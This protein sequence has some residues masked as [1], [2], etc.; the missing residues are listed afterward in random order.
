ML[1]DERESDE[2]IYPTTG[3][4][5]KILAI[6]LLLVSTINVAQSQVVIVKS[7]QRQP[8]AGSSSSAGNTGNTN[9]TGTTNAKSKIK[10]SPSPTPKLVSKS[11]PNAKLSQRTLTAD[12]TE[13]P[14][15]FKVVV[16]QS[17]PVN[18]G[19]RSLIPGN[20]SAAAELLAYR[21]SV[22]T[23]DDRGRETERRS[24]S[25][26]YYKEKLTDI[27]QVEMVEI[28]AGAFKMGSVESDLEELKKE[29]TR[30]VDKNVKTELLRRVQWELPQ[31]LVKIPTF[32]MSK[33]E[34]TQA[35]WR[36][37][38]SLPKINIDLVSDPSQ[39]K[40]SERPVE[41]VSW[42][43]AAEFCER[44]SQATGRRYRLPSEAEW[45]Y[46]CRAGTDSPYNFGG[47]MKTD[48]ANFHGK[49]IYGSLPKGVFREQT[50]TVGSLGIANAF[51]LYDMHGNVWEW[52]S[53]TWHENYVTGPDD[54]RSWESGEISY[55]KILRGGG[56]DSSAAECRSNSRNKMTSTIRL[57]NIGF[58]VVAEIPNQQIVNDANLT[59]R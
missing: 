47:S 1:G 3:N 2:I 14:L 15:D 29:Y 38:A 33:F 5:K 45:E 36:A 53:D 6:F 4:F 34:V 44:L 25:A 39:F 21:F 22:I 32:Y 46:A 13:Q 9:S 31:H 11:Q 19:N 35:Q 43:E 56:F 27:V 16:P 58:R 48:W 40:G 57:N 23:A 10:P 17:L 28:P 50:V 59:V 41:G 51:G 20:N 7:K 52:C 37:V 26:R 12:T 42:E 54:G 18:A 49:R 8:R 24:E 55:L 30:G